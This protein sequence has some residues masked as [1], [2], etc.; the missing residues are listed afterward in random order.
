MSDADKIAAAADKVVA[1]LNAVQGEVAKVGDQL[2]RFTNGFQADIPP[3][4]AA[5]VESAPA[6][7]AALETIASALDQG[8]K[9]SS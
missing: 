8:L 7:V 2:E 6:A 5:I 3:A 9:P 4:A 1:A